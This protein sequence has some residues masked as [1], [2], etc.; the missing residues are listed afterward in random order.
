MDYSCRELFG[1]ATVHFTE[2]HHDYFDPAMYKNNRNIQDMIKKGLYN[3]DLIAASCS[4]RCWGNCPALPR[5][6]DGVFLPV[7][8][9][10]RR[11]SH[12]VLDLLFCARAVC[13][14]IV[15]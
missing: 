15:N 6:S 10:G 5:I 14:L 2:A 4:E 9:G 13:Q 7:R 1:P 3:S 8:C 11:C 12:I